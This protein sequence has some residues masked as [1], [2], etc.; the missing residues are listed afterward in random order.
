MVIR[1]FDDPDFTWPTLD[2]IVSALERYVHTAA[3]KFLVRGD[4]GQGWY[5]NKRL[6]IPSQCNNLLQRLMVIAHCGAQAHRGRAAM[7]EHFQRHFHVDHLRRK[8]DRFLAV[9]LLCHH[10]KGGKVVQRPWSETFRCHERNR[11]LHWDFL[12]KFTVAYSPWINGSIERVNRDVIQV[13]R[14]LCLE[15]KKDIR[16]WTMFV[17]LLGASI[18]HTPVPSLGNK[19]PVE[20][21]CALPLPSPLE[22]CVNLEQREVLELTEQP[23]LIEQKLQALR[24]S[25]QT[26]HKAVDEERDQQ[27]QRNKKDQRG[28]KKANFSVGD[29]VLRSRVDQK[30]QDKLLVTWV[31]PYQI[32]RADTHS[33]AVRH[34]VTGAEMNVHGS[35]LKYYADKDFEVTEEV[36]EHVASQGI[37]LA[38]SELKDHRWC[39]RKK[40]YEVLVAWK[41]LEP[42]EDSW[43]TVRSLF[44]DIPVLLRAYVSRAA[45]TGLTKYLERASRFAPS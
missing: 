20:L 40:D 31:G 41:G 44:K 12:T 5:H 35:G 3:S 43:E 14:V 28:A 33:F 26:M 45:D 36:R 24:A 10:V 4:S 19:S 42:I 30:H 11:P 18:N 23:E 27:T 2:E 37:V 17:P 1:P 6:W 34:L 7:M 16:D 8:V 13:L 9:C 32:M 21:F 15:H 22:F 38:V 25:V 39:P 29:Y